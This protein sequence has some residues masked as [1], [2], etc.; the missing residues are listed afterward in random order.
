ME[1]I[2]LMMAGIFPGRMRMMSVFIAN[3][4]CTMM[5]IRTETIETITNNGGKN[6]SNY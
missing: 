6:D 1:A 4:K 2:I 5:A 3:I